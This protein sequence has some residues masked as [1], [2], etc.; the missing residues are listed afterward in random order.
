MAA[1]EIAVYRYR[2]LDDNLNTGVEPAR[3]QDGKRRYATMAWI[4]AN[5][6]VQVVPDSERRVQP[7]ELDMNGRCLLP[8]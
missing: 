5:R 1:T 4:Q 2:G 3:D 8:D 7:S 6:N